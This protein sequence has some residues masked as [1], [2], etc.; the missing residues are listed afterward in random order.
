MIVIKATGSPDVKSLR[1]LAK[2]LSAEASDISID[3][4]DMAPV[5]PARRKAGKPSVSTLPG[6]SISP[7]TQAAI[8]QLRP[9]EVE[10]S[11]DYEFC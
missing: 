7:E 1:R 8:M 6:A 9:V 2:S 3:D 11:G 10:A 5:A 4:I